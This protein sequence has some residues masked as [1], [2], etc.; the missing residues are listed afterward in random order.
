MSDVI[1]MEVNT[2]DPE[3]SGAVVWIVMALL[4]FIGGVVALVFYA[5][6]P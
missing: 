5:C 4:A 6:V 2:E 1:K 3:G